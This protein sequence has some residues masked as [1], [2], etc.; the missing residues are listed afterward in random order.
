MNTSD[1][2]IYGVEFDPIFSEVEAILTQSEESANPLSGEDELPQI[3][4]ITISEKTSELLYQYKDLRVLLWSLRANLYIDGISSLFSGIKTL[5]ELIENNSELLYPKSED[6][7]I[8]SGHAAALG[9]LSASQCISELKLTK[10]TA[11]HHYT[12]NDIASID[13]GEIRDNYATSLSALLTSLTN[14]DDIN[15]SNISGHFSSVIQSLDKIEEYANHYT[16]G[17]ILDCSALKQFLTRCISTL[18]QLA[19]FSDTDTHSEPQESLSDGSNPETPVTASLSG[20]VRMADIT[21]RS[22]QEVLIMLDCI[23][24]YFQRYEP[25]H[26]VPIFI[27]RSKQM[28]GM[29]FASIVEKLL[30]ESVS[31]LQQFTGK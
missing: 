28:I 20:P 12:L 25:S 8:R 2:D 26:P 9:W 31:T 6:G 14:S 7:D 11:D 17:Y 4:W 23:L 29:D 27:Q 19:S 1:H 18:N 22:R 3:N 10:I 24:D 15:I 16:D 30:P 13:S 21:L 5:N